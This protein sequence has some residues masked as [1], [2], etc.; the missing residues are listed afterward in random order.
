MNIYERLNRSSKNSK[1]LAEWDCI[2][3]DEKL[4]EEKYKLLRLVRNADAIERS[5]HFIADGLCYKKVNGH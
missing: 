5:E 2:G 4:E 1:I 3:V